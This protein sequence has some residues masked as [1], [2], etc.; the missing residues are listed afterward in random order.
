M[1]LAAGMLPAIAVHVP[2]DSPLHVPAFAWMGQELVVLYIICAVVS[3][4]GLFRML[5]GT[6]LAGTMLPEKAT[7]ATVD[8]YCCNAVDRAAAAAQLQAEQD[9]Y[10]YAGQAWLEP[11]TS[12]CDAIEEGCSL[13]YA[14]GMQCF[15][16]RRDGLVK[17][18]CV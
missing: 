6:M 18:V 3:T 13:D 15:E 10:Y 2:A 11:L 12:L 5:A 9:A 17:R 8:S 4:A 1:A 14:D 7:T 16:V